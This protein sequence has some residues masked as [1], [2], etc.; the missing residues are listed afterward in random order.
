MPSYTLHKT[1]FSERLICDWNAP[2]WQLAEPLDIN[3]FRSESG[4]HRPR[5][6]AR[7]LY[8]E[9]GIHGIF[10]VEDRYVRCLRSG[11][12]SEVWKDS[13]VEFFVKPKV[14]KGYF[15]FEF[16]C[17]G[18][19]L[20]YY[21]TNHERRPGGFKEFVKVSYERAHVVRTASTLP[22]IVDPEIELPVTWSLNFFIPFALLESFVGDLAASLT[23]NPW[24][25]NLYKCGDETSR[26]HWAA[27]S[28]VDE[29]NFHLPRCFG[30]LRF[31][32]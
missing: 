28:P 9:S 24:Q 26:P 32:A 20:C 14:D 17:G 25:A 16:N 21:I 3:H 13:C 4:T 30:T 6:R 31:E 7:L 18:S 22:K 5:T 8:D 10:Q 23:K 1:N 15:N 11:F 19:F 2:A 29:F 27:W 12:Q